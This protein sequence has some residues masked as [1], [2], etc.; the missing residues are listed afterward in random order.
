MTVVSR[1]LITGSADGL[2]LLAARE[3]IAGGHEV[4]LHGRTESRAHEARDAAPGAAG[5]L[6]GDLASI[7][8]IRELAAAADAG[9]PFHAVIHNAGVGFS[10]RRTVTADGLEHVFVINVLAPYLLTALMDR[11]Q[12]LV[13]L[14]SGMHRGG[15][16]DF[17]DLQWERRRW[18]SAQAY[19]DAKF[20]DTALAFAIARRWPAVHSNAVSPGW[21][22][23]RM[24]GA[25][26]PDAL[27]LGARTQS[28]LAAG[29]DPAADVSGEL[30]YHQQRTE[31]QPRTRD[32]ELQDRL[33]EAC[34]AV[35]GVILADA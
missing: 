22:A 27:A 11:P 17:E 16:P 10:E 3:L 14:S 5:A 32:P 12:R 7:D 18:Q 21:V 9:G 29:D 33:L 34:A 31:P 15:D 4:V 23:T 28:W 24:G 20:L 2:G 30:L 35:S 26:A 1:I 13:Y 6:A 25:G 19:S 8:E